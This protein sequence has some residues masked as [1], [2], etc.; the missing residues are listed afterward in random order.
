MTTTI[1]Q[2]EQLRR[3]FKS[4]NPFMVLMWRMG[5]G[6]MINIWPSRIGRIM[7]LAHTGRKTGR[8]RL[9]PVNYTE[10]NGEIYCVAGFGAVADWYRNL[11]AN[12]AVEIWMPNGWWNASAEDIS[13]HPNRLDLMRQVLIASGFA[14]P[15]AGIHPL[16]DTDEALQA[17]TAEYRLVRIRRSAARTG[18]GGPGE[19]AWLWPLM[20]FFL[21]PLTLYL[22]LTRTRR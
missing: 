3:T 14:A 13:D 5:L 21:A 22:L 2:D 20:V 8:R 18:P 4:F 15:L 10:I 19:L 7:V 11:Q 6:S 12:P 17:N 9:T 16:T 1:Q